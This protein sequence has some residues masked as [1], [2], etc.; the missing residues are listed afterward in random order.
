M[1]RLE[2]VDAGDA[3]AH[4]EHRADLGD[5]D[6]AEVGGLDFLEEDVLE[7]AGTE[8]GFGG[9]ESEALEVENEGQVVL[10]KIITSE[11]ASKGKIP[12]KS[13][14]HRAQ[15]GT[16]ARRLSGPGRRT[17][18]VLRP[19][20]LSPY[21]RLRI[22]LRTNASNTRIG[23]TRRSSSALTPAIRSAVMPR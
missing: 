17:I 21:P 9:H 23:A 15:H 5:V 1:A 20:A 22:A 14:E 8:D 10:V 12:A 13:I 19:C 3:V 4:L 18:P 7:F 11:I 6:R 16:G 2:A